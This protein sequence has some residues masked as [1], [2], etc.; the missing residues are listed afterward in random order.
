VSATRR[1]KLDPH[2]Q[3]LLRA[4]EALLH[5][6]CHRRAPG[7]HTLE[8]ARQ[9]RFVAS[10]QFQL[11][12]DC[13]WMRHFSTIAPPKCVPRRLWSQDVRGISLQEEQEC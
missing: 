4:S 5:D 13:A 8:S 7:Q 2:I 10:T 12:I 11:R 6:A 9:P 1:P 3:T